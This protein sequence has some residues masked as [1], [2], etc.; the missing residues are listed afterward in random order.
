MTSLRIYMV[1]NYTTE[2]TTYNPDGTT[3]AVRVRNANGSTV[4]G[5][6]YTYAYTATGR[7]ISAKTLN[8]P[9]TRVETYDL[10]DRKVKEEAQTTAKTLTTTYEY[11]YLKNVIAAKDARANANSWGN[12]TTATYDHMGN[13]LTQTNALGNTITNTYNLMGQL[14]SSSDY[15][16]NVTTYVYDKMGRNIQVSTPFDSTN[17]SKKF[18]IYDKNGNVIREKC[19]NNAPGEGETYRTVE[20]VYNSKNQV[21]AVKQF[22][23]NTEY[24]TAYTYD[25]AG[26]QTSLITGAATN[27]PHTTSYTYN[28]L[29]QVVSETDPMGGAKTAAYDYLGNVTGGTTKAGETITN[30][31][32]DWN[33]PVLQQ[34]TGTNPDTNEIRTDTRSFTYDSLGRKISATNESGTATYEYDDFGRL[35][36]ET[37]VTGA[38]KEYTYDENGN[39]LTFTLTIDGTQQMNATYTYDKLNQ[40]T[41]VIIG[42][43]TTTYGYDENGNIV[44]KT[45]G[46]LVTTYSYNAGN[47]LTEMDTKQS[48]ADRYNYTSTYYLDGNRKYVTDSQSYEYWYEYDGRGQLIYEGQSNYDYYF[49]YDAY[50]NRTKKEHG[51]PWDLDSVEYTYDA[52]NRLVKEVNNGYYYVDNYNYTN[53]ITYGYD[54]NGNQTYYLNETVMDEP[55]YGEESMQLGILGENDTAGGTTR[56]YTYN[57]FGER[58]GMLSDNRT[59]EYE[60][61]PDGLRVSKTINGETTTHILDGANVVADVKNGNVAKYNRG[62]ELISMEQNGQKGYYIFNG[63]GDVAKMVMADGVHTSRTIYNAYGEY[64]EYWG[65]TDTTDRLGRLANPFQYA[66]EYRDIETGQYYLRARY[67]DPSTGRFV[68]EDP[69]KDGANWYSYAGNN[70]VMYVDKNGLHRKPIDETINGQTVTTAEREDLRELL[71]QMNGVLKIEGNIVKIQ[72][73]GGYAEIN[74]NTY[75]DGVHLVQDHLHFSYGEFFELLGLNYEK[76]SLTV[77]VSKGEENKNRITYAFRQLGISVVKESLIKPIDYAYKGFSAIF[78]NLTGFIGDLT[79]DVNSAPPIIPAGTYQI[80]QYTVAGKVIIQQKIGVSSG[81][82][83]YK[84]EF[85]Y[86]NPENPSYISDTFFGWQTP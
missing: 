29:G 41:G 38:V 79:Q 54:A 72:A 61:N 11:D 62:R 24:K 33:L 73:L 5:T 76:T 48:G 13:V 43:D 64:V 10:R 71:K 16:G 47:M 32:N 66:G 42:G 21:T 18:V 53:T 27:A 70:P 15:K 19:Q 74:L 28:K 75:N 12:T 36:K 81:N 20:Y 22:D 56:M 25:N 69:I 4:T 55:V 63:H 44:N 34:V 78:N 60:Y 65:E 35:A 45:T 59:V 80:N 40:L 39:R 23:G 1:S 2:E 26:N 46:A 49:T 85:I 58:T 82:N 68:S 31:Y 8:D 14:M 17:V 9:V 6:D 84:T 83:Y 51:G 52:N 37:D 57:G 77:Q 67:Y 3:A 50:G 30:T 7:S 86:W